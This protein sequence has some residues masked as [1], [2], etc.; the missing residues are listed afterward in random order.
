MLNII[1]IKNF[2]EDLIKR[3]GINKEYL[4]DNGAIYYY[5]GNDGTDFDY[6]AN[7][8]TCE[9][10]VFWKSEDGAIKVNQRGDK[11]VAYVYDKEDPYNTSKAHEY[12]EDSPFDLYELCCYLQGTFDDRGIHNK[13]ITEWNLDIE[14]YIPR[15]DE[16]EDW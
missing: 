14:G 9:F 4:Y 10:F 7:N 13:E 11:L 5:N 15:F 16:E 1:K 8:M 3:E 2:I 6:S 12:T